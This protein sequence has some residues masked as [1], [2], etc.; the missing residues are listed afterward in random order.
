MAMISG[1]VAEKADYI[2]A[3]N[4]ILPDFRQ[5][6]CEKIGITPFAH[7]AAWWAASDGLILTDQI[8]PDDAPPD[9]YRLIR[10]PDKSIVKRIVQPAPS[11]RARFIADL[12]AYKTGKSLG[13]AIWAAAFAIVPGAKIEFVGIEYDACS[14]EFEFLIEILLSQRGFNLKARSVQNRP[15]DGKM[16][17]DLDNDVQYIARSWERKDTMKGKERDAYIFCLPGDAPI[18]MGDYTQKALKDVC[19][20]DQVIGWRKRHR[21]EQTKT[22]RGVRTSDKLVKSRVLATTK[23]RGRLI[24]IEMAS[25]RVLYSTLNHRWLVSGTVHNGEQAGYEYR[26]ADKLHIG[27]RLAFVVDDQGTCPAPL[28]ETAAWLGGMYD[29]EGSVD[30]IAQSLTHNADLVVEIE[31]AFDALGFKTSRLGPNANGGVCVRYLGGL[32]SSV[33]F[34]TWV[35]SRRFRSKYADRMILKGRFRRLDEIVGLKLLDGEHDVYCLTTETENFI[36]YGYCSH[37]SE[38]YQLPGLEVFTNNKQNLDARRGYAVFPTTP[39]RPWITTLHEL[40]HDPSEP[41][42]TCFCGVPRSVNPYAYDA[43]GAERDRRTMTKERYQIHYGGMI[44]EYVGSVFGYQ[45][46]HATFTTTTH[47]HLWKNPRESATIDNLKIP[48]TWEVIGSTDSGTF[49]TSLLVGFDEYGFAYVLEE[50]A[51]YRYVVGE[52]EI[53]DEISIP[54]WARRTASAL[55]RYGASKTLWTDRQNQMKRELRRYG[56][57]LRSVRADRATRTEIAREYFRKNRIFLAP[58]LQLLPTE[59]EQAQWPEGFD[60]NRVERRRRNDHSLD[61]LEHILTQRPVGY[62]PEHRPQFSRFID[63]ELLR[64]RQQQPRTDPHGL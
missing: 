25:G 39:D 12:T 46:G 20:G 5:R 45:K 52:I 44:G 53:L 1:P 30:A 16:W 40:G 47:P 50:F 22:T 34:A 10:L 51:N 62:V 3:R 24:R 35:P 32:A 33:K 6:I 26:R 13:S 14:A 7:Q 58:W 29:G 60:R 49:Y 41:D 21:S 4:R 55:K 8:A 61:C 28:K 18:W 43:D 48:P 23:Q 9:T 31:K 59:L 2:L 11:G 54:V 15:R 37:N 42:W 56:L 63:E 27:Q 64:M 57:Q 17:I 19:V 38:A 36:A